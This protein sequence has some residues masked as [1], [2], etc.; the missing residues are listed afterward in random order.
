L[1]IAS[2]NQWDWCRI[3]RNWLLHSPKHAFNRRF[4]H[5]LLVNVRLA[6]LS[7]FNAA[8]SI[9]A[10][11]TAKLFLRAFFIFYSPVFACYRQG[12]EQ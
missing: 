8:M 2:G 1:P 9:L 3:H 4:S 6:G 12:I 11:K 10:L 7:H 5:F